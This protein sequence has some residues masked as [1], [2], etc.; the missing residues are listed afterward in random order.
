ME[1]SSAVLPDQLTREELEIWVIELRDQ[2]R[3][4]RSYTALIKVFL[5][6]N[7]EENACLRK[8]LKI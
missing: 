1:F 2:Y 7:K 8:K 3:N 6:R 5:D 4:L